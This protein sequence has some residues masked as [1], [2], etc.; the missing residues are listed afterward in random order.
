MVEILALS[1]SPRKGGNSEAL[2]DSFLEGAKSGGAEFKIIRVA[3]EKINPCRA[4][5]A[6]AETGMCIIRDDMQEIYKKISAA[7]ALVLVSP[8]FFGGVSAQMKA[9]LDRFQ[10]FWFLNFGPNA[11]GKKANRKL[12]FFLAVGGMKNKKYCEAVRATASAS[13]ANM[14]MKFSGFLCLQGYDKKGEIE[15]DAEALKTAYA[16]GLEFA[17]RVK[18]N[19]GN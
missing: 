8:I 4:C 15:K 17:F 16:E 1:G 5:D 12:G 13:F 9:A 14:A 3:D 10:V 7:D 18:E 2:L 19:R 11:K 6:C